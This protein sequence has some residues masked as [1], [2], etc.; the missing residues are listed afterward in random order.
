MKP[1]PDPVLLV[2]VHDL[3]RHVRER[4]DQSVTATKTADQHEQA[5]DIENA[6]LTLLDIEP[7]LYEATT[8]INAASIINRVFYQ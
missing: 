1:M 8:L 2:S 5:G 6:V 3:L 7:A 4:V